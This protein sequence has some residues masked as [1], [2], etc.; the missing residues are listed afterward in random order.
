[1]KLL[2]II[3]VQLIYVPMLSLRTVCMVKNLK[4][5][6]T[7]FGFLEAMVYIFGLAIV[8]SG[9][10]NYTEMFVYALGYAL[11]L[12]VG[13]VVE[14]KLAIGYSS[15]E[16]NI[17]HEN[18]QMIHQ[19]REKGY[20]VTV[21]EGQGRNGKRLRL[22]ILTKRSQEKGLL[23][24]ILEMEPDAFIMSYEPKM[25][26]GGYIGEMMKKRLSLIG[27][28]SMTSTGGVFEQ[29]VEEIKEEIS[30]IKHEWQ[31]DDSL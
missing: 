1:M 15:F 21:Y 8:L 20:G 29:T 4:A 12:L 28:R 6:T 14:Q 16:V 13:Q 22:D 10:Q 3:G 30:T 11:G 5:L 17:N 2:L 9:N 26:K 19:L 25:F 27:K 24:I 23:D 18:P 7:V 31:E